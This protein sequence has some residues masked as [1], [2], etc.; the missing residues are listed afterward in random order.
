MASIVSRPLAMLLATLVVA[1]SAWALNASYWAERY[2]PWGT[3]L[4]DC[5]WFLPQFDD[6]AYWQTL[7]GGRFHLRTPPGAVLHRQSSA[8]GTIEGHR[9]TLIYTLAIADDGGAFARTGTD[10]RE[11]SAIVGGKPALLRSAVFKDRADPLFLQLVVPRAVR[12]KDGRWL[13]LEIH[14]FQR[15]SERNWLAERV[16][17]TIDFT[18]PYDVP[19]SPPVLRLLLPTI[20]VETP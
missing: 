9:Y 2:G 7:Y 17:R 11:E 12:T 15:T 14:G 6:S 1:A 13:A 16:L 5:Y 19:L 8:S 20:E 4:C 18:P 3:P 10:Y